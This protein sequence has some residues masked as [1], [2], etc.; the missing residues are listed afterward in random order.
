MFVFWD[1]LCRVSL[2]HKKGK[3]RAPSV[4]LRLSADSSREAADQSRSSVCRVFSLHF[5][6]LGLTC[7]S[8]SIKYWKGGKI[9]HFVP[10]AALAGEGL[11]G[12]EP[13]PTLECGCQ[14]ES[15]WLEPP[16]PVELPRLPRFKWSP[17][18]HSLLSVLSSSRVKLHQG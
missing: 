2:T 15:L 17:P 10:V 12:L 13:S 4:F 11:V 5:W 16:P 9:H 1:Q 8:F 18:L 6:S 14:E 3:T 7:A